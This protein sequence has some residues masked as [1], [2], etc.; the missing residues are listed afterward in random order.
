M[1]AE[2]G[3][4]G[5]ETDPPPGSGGTGEWWDIIGSLDGLRELVGG[6]L[7]EAVSAFLSP[8]ETIGNAIGSL[9]DLLSS[10]WD[11]IK[12][13]GSAINSMLGWFN[14]LSENFFL[15]KAFVPSENYFS[16]KLTILKANM[17][18]KLAAKDQMRSAWEAVVAKVSYGDQWQGFKATIPLIG[19][20]VTIVDPAFVNKAAPKIKFWMA[21]VI[22]LVLVLWTYRKIALYL[23]D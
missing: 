19:K 10:V 22:Y 12:G 14:P 3:G 1:G 15:R 5:G 11:A 8:L 20:E 4:G 18:A 17:D 2:P 13:I 9:G 6:W 7:G 16:E 21:G 23:K